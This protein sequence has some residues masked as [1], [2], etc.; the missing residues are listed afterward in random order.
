MASGGDG[1]VLAAEAP[2]ELPLACTMPE[3]CKLGA[4]S[5]GAALHAIMASL[6]AGIHKICIGTRISFEVSRVPC[7]RLWLQGHCSHSLQTVRGFLRC[8]RRLPCKKPLPQ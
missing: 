7:A 6:Q 5:T 8:R 2:Y 3:E 1:G 4:M